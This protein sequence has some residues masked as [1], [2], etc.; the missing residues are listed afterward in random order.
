MQSQ[1]R[2]TLWQYKGSSEINFCG[3]R[4]PKTPATAG[5]GWAHSRRLWARGASRG[6]HQRG[7]RHPGRHRA[8][9]APHG[10]APWGWGDKM[11]NKG[12][13]FFCWKM[14]VIEWS[15]F[16]STSGLRLYS[17]WILCWLSRVRLEWSW[18]VAWSLEF[19][20]LW[21]SYHT[22]HTV[23]HLPELGVA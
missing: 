11:E 6:G 18:K 10:T 16:K 3:P 1:L 13:M 4:A 8:L 17:G 9:R 14:Y 12:G 2:Q 5:E 20:L 22:R 7:L 23:S 21:Q 15:F 19:P